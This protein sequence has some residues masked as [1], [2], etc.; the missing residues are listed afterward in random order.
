MNLAWK[1]IRFN[2]VKFVLTAVGVGAMVAATI[3]I[4]GLY[5]GIVHEALL[6]IVEGGA[7]LW[8]VQ[9]NTYGPF[10]E[11][12]RVSGTLDRR[13]EGVP[14]VEKVRRFIQYSRQF[15]LQWPALRHVR[16]GP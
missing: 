5:R 1:D 12:S 10:S 8:V 6:M 15:Y 3:G 11:M 4:V 9:G 2:H 14:G 16:H 13:V 7:D